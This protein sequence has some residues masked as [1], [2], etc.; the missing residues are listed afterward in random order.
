MTSPHTQRLSVTLERELPHAPEKVWQALTKKHLIEDW[1][2]QNDFE[3]VIG[4][5]FTLTSNWGSIACEVL[6]ADPPKSLAYRWDSSGLE[7][8]VTWTLNAIEGGT[9]LRIDQTGFK[10]DFIAAYNGAKAGWPRFLGG[11]ERVL[12]GME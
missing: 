4:H 9:L 1:L 10:S 2:M 5:R 7:S 3:P 12:A 8:V 11:L 6:E